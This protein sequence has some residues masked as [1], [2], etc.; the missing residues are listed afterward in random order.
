M[1]KNIGILRINF[2]CSLKVTADRLG[3]SAS[4][5][6]KIENGVIDINLSRLEQIANFYRVNLTELWTLDF[7]NKALHDSNL[8]IA[9]KKVSD[10]ESEIAT[11]Q[12]K[13][14]FLYEKLR[15]QSA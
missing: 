4:F 3:M 13:I 6:T 11:F 7:E 10:L 5:L 12:T 9:R 15:D 1:G 2:G 8:N 14:I